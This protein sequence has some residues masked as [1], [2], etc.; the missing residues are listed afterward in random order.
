[1]IYFELN[2]IICLEGHNDLISIISKNKFVKGQ[3]IN[4]KDRFKLRVIRKMLKVN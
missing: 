3:E 4:T 1:V 2:Q